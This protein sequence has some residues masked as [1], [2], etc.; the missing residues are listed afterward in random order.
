M[1][2]G[3]QVDCDKAVADRDELE[4]MIR[5]GTGRADLQVGH[6]RLLFT[7][8][9]GPFCVHSHEPDYSRH[10]GLKRA[11]PR[12]SARAV[13]SSL[14]VSGA[15]PIV[16]VV[17]HRMLRLRRSSCPHPI[18]WARTEHQHSGCR[19]SLACTYRRRLLIFAQINLGWKLSLVAKEVAAPS[20]L[21]SYNAER[22][23]IIAEM[24]K[25]SSTLFNKFVQ[26]KSGG[27]DRENAWKRGGDLHQFGVNYR[28][29]PI[30]LDERT[31]KEDT[32]VDPYGHTRSPTDILRAGERAPDAPGLVI[33]AAKGGFN[34]AH[35]TTS[36]FS[37][38][39]A[40]HHTVLI[41]SDGSEKV[42][43]VVAALR[44]YPADLFKTV[45]VRT[46]TSAPLSAPDGVDWC[47]LDRDAHAHE[48]YQVQKHEFL[49]VVVRPDGS[50]GGITRG[51]DG[52]GRYFNGVFNNVAK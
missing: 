47:V 24:L 10:T 36:L 29:S 38:F 1:M 14:V 43:E 22:P 15:K 28:W 30:V 51:A 44:A 42:S 26:A 32:P 18:W 3:G 49:V 16:T 37:L 25:L 6:I 2:L 7:F 4:R 19:T 41:F 52:T 46:D 21:D 13:Y 8:R 40:S 48:G 34:M 5:I 17:A 11:W 27:K 31:P 39:G 45:L 50:I 20:L 9:Y 35:A 12:S 23:P 33:L